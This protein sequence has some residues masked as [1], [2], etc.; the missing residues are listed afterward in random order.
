MLTALPQLT[1]HNAVQE[2]VKAY[3]IENGLK[4]GDK[5]PSET[6]LTRS[7]G[8]SRTAV[9][10]ALRGLEATGMIETRHG[11][12]RYVKAFEFR[13]IADNLAYS[14]TVDLGSIEDLLNVRRALEIWFLPEAIAAMTPAKLSDLDAHVAQMRRN[15]E[16][17]ESFEAADMEFH[18]VLFTG[19]RNRVLQ[20]LLTIFWRLFINL[21]QQGALPPGNGALTV[22]YHAAIV[23][24]IREGDVN[25]AKEVMDKHFEDVKQR[26]KQTKRQPSR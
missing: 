15:L 21:Q 24:A 6:V 7:L 19:V 14:L 2:R 25:R 23:A 18:R 10:E 3:I 22:A 8:V 5:L 1:T 17:G 20:E 16:A 13:S 4:P 12:G 11:V 26:L 9:R